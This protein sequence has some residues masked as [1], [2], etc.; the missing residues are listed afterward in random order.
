V[1]Q[2]LREHKQTNSSAHVEI[3]EDT[4]LMDSGILDSL[5]FIELLLFIDSKSGCQIDLTD[6][7]PAE[8]SV[9]KS[10][11]EIALRNHQKESSNAPDY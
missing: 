10:L 5:G 6:V 8:F 1:M 9:V 7:D 3:T 4:N 2:W 11:C